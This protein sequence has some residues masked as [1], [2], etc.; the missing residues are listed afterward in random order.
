MA[1]YNER[2]YWLGFAT[3]LCICAFA[4]FITWVI[5]EYIDQKEEGNQ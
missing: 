5:I 2:I 4:H 3:A 1:F